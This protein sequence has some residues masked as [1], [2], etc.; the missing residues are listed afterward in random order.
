[1]LNSSEEV[2]GWTWIDNQSRLEDLTEE[3]GKAG[4]IALDTEFHREKTY[5]PKLALV[6]IGWDDKVALLDPFA[7]D[8]TA[9]SSVFSGPVTVVLHAGT[10]DLEILSRI[11][12]NL[13]QSIFDT[14]LAAGFVGFSNPSLALLSERL[15]GI[16]IPKGD[17]LTDWT[18]R[19]LSE[20]QLRYAASDVANLL[21][22]K[23]EIE[24][25][26]AAMGR[27]EWAW[28]ESKVLLNKDRRGT[29][30]ER[31]WWKIKECRHLKGESRKV[32]QA[33]AVWRELRA[34]RLD[35][36]VRYVLSDLSI[37]VISQ[38]LPKTVDALSVL[39]GVEHRFL[40]QGVDREILETVS[41][42]RS[43]PD[44]ELCVPVIEE[45]DKRLKP[46]A[47]M[48]VTWV[49][50]LAQSLKIDP[51]L[52][53]TRSDIVGFLN[54]DKDSRLAAG[55]RNEVLGDPITRLTNGELA[56]AVNAN[57]ELELEKRSYVRYDL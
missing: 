28:D 10:Q 22:L 4:E 7:L 11:V 13:P 46:I 32:A 56:L 47:G 12:G 49:S 29:P 35:V 25:Q 30:I 41:R 9:L 38:E 15:L 39:R 36:P 54:G 17:R 33:L 40:A 1:M 57:G 55:W 43:M 5:Y 45:S 51:L 20:G 31:T 2:Q 48:A 19:P 24:D 18:K 8:L 44:K 21:S 23:S 3:F 26:L 53:A 37:A 14:Q 16:A 52:L 34:A 27:L 50:Q 42:G 6:Q